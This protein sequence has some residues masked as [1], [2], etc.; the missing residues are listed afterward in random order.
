MN[1]RP[2]DEPTKFLHFFRDDS[3]IDIVIRMPHC[4]HALH[5]VRPIVTDVTRS[6]VCVS[7]CLF[8]AH[9][10]TVQKRLN[11]SRCRLGG[12]HTWVQT[13]SRSD[14]SIRRR[15]GWQDGDARM[16]ALVKLLRTLMCVRWCFAVQCRRWLAGTTWRSHDVTSPWRRHRDPGDVDDNDVR[17][18]DN[19]VRSVRNESHDRHRPDAGQRHDHE[20]RPTRRRSSRL[21][22]AH[23]FRPAAPRPVN[24]AGAV[25][26]DE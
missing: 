2:S 24:E 10:W 5:E 1:P 19:D 17:D 4:L 25:A 16:R 9:G 11:R 14:E 22:N 26:V 21:G 15:E 7:V 3:T 8:W 23:G 18:D 6:V 20:R 13:R 12:W